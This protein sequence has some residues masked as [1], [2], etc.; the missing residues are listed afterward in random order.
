MYLSC[1]FA[2]ED[3]VSLQSDKN[4]MVPLVSICEGIK[5]IS[6]DRNATI[7][8]VHFTTDISELEKLRNNVFAYINGAYNVENIGNVYIHGDGAPWIM[9]GLDKIGGS[10][11]ALD[12]FHLQ[13]KLKPF[14][15]SSNAECINELLS[16]ERKEDFE[17]AAKAIIKDCADVKKKN[18]LRKT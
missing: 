8:L 6:K 16:S 11:F 9:K 1:I 17:L 12:G 5:E 7:N 14:I 3:H 10:V 15:D 18:S 2:D 4:N 13:R